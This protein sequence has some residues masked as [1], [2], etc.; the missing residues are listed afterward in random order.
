[1]EEFYFL[2]SR[3]S[4]IVIE[5]PK[6]NKGWNG[7]FIRVTNPNGFGVNLRWRTA[8]ASGNRAPGVM[9]EEQEY[10]DK[11][12]K[13]K[14]PWKLVLDKGEIDSYWPKADSFRAD[15]LTAAPFD[16][17]FSIGEPNQASFT[18]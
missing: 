4:L 18:L 1:M 13:C 10:Y 3:D 12:L 7:L 17:D 5:L 15:P 6:N 16:P 14:Y 11:L 2:Q 8:N 9:P